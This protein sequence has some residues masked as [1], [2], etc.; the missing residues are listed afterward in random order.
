VTHH[1]FLFQGSIPFEDIQ[2][3]IRISES[4]KPENEGG[5]PKR[6]KKHAE[7]VTGMAPMSMTGHTGYLTAAT[8]PPIWARAIR[9]SE[10]QPQSSA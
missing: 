3:G 8:L 4:Q 7:F 2:I 10:E 6:S 9:P 1:F 5:K